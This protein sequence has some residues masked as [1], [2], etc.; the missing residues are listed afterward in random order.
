MAGTHKTNNTLFSSD[1]SSPGYIQSVASSKSKTKEHLRTP[2]LIPSE[3][4]DVSGGIELLLEAYYDYMNLQEFIYQENETYQDIVLDGKAVFRVVDPRNENDHFFTDDDGANSTLTLTDDRGIIKTFNLQNLN[5]AISNGNNLPGS[6]ANST[7]DIG[8]TLTV[9]GLDQVV[10]VNGAVT[11]SVD[12]VLAT[13]DSTITPGQPVS[14]IGIPANVTVDEINGTSL[15]LTQPVSLD[16]EVALTFSNNTKTATITTPVKYWAG[17]GASYTLNTIEE[18]LDIDST[19]AS[20]LELIQKEIAAVVPRSIQVNKRN[21]YKAI[22][23][24]YKIRGSSDS[25]EVFFRL[26]FDDEV[27]VEYPWNE[28]LIPSSGNWEVNSSLPKGGVYLDKKGFLSDTIKIQDSLKYQKFS[29][30][31]RTGQSLSAWDFFYNRLVH[32]AG[33]KYFAEILIQLFGTRDELGDDQKIAGPI[34]FIGGPNHGLP[35]GESF[36]G[37]GRQNRITYSSMPDLQ[38]GV[39][40]LEDVPLLVDLFASLFLPF[41]EVNIHQSAKI[42][43]TVEQTST[44]ANYGKVVSAEIVDS[45]FGYTSEPSVTINGVPQ[46]GQTITPAQITTTI[47]SLGRVT[48]TNIT[49]PGDNYNSAFA[50]VLANPNLSKVASVSIVPSTTKRYSTPPEVIFTDPTSTGDNGLPLPTNVTATGKYIL[51]PTSV[52]SVEMNSVGS[53]YTT[54]PDIVFSDPD[55]FYTAQPFFSDNFE[56]AAIGDW[57][58]NYWHIVGTDDHTASIQTVGGSKVLQV[59]TST[60]DTNASGSIGGAVYQLELANPEFTNRLP[61]NTVKIKCRAKKPTSGGANTFRMAYSTS[62]HGNSG[63]QVFNLTNS[64]QEFEFEYNISSLNP[65]N[66]DYVGFQGDGNDGIVYI[67]DVSI[68]VKKDFPRV[69]SDIEDGRLNSITVLYK[70]SGYKEVP[71]ISISGNATAVAQLVPSKVES[72]VIVNPGFGYVFDPLI[73]ISSKAKNENRAKAQPV[74]KIIELN[75]TDVDP[76]F[77]KVNNPV[78]TNPSVRG[79]QLYNGGLLQKGV[80]SSGQ[81]WTITQSTPAT[82]KTMGGY[83][84]TVVAAGYRTQVSNNYYNQKTNILE[85]NMLYDFNETL[86][87]LGDVE[88]QSTS[89]SDINKYNVNSFIH[90]N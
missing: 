11:N 35:T 66:V 57:D 45:G 69:I 54:H 42:A 60:L 49:N 14:G 8:K 19:A 24:Y 70:G 90:N 15:K 29:Y 73:Y 89:I 78:Q 51:E 68:T 76:L 61:G 5:V 83:D 28:T 72:A 13:S 18:S 65:T 46:T 17:P 87:V 6:L 71:S 79:R 22:T 16:D 43:L 40:G 50:N 84:V 77:N 62:Q 67:D 21:L 64:W 33:F 58:D 59:Q 86:E 2:E 44:D 85:N 9:H 75:H 4:L 32:P 7:S 88:L 41:T 37:Y 53:N 74:K 52:N 38:P 30:L 34:N 36:E 80:L 20:Y 3:I 81:N 47:D 63:W 56:N 23:D 10:L 39:I 27:E 25:I 26:L 12:V 82:D 1:I 31:I 55:V 48:G